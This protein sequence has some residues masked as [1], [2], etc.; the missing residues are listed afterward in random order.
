M[1]QWDAVLA[2]A[3]E[4]DP[5]NSALTYGVYQIFVEL[6]TSHTDDTTGGTVWDYVELHTALTALKSL[7]KDYY[8]SEIVPVLFQYEF[9]K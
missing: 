4:T 9:L 8:N 1:Q 6:D 2:R 3:K 7:V 5:Y